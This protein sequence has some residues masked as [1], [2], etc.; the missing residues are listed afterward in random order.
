MIEAEMDI[1]ENGGPVRLVSE[2]PDHEMTVF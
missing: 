2:L 1:Q